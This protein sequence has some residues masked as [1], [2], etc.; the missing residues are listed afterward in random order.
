MK[1]ESIT[2][3]T[4]KKRYLQKSKVGQPSTGPSSLK[5]YCTPALKNT[6]KPHAILYTPQGQ[7]FFCYFLALCS[8]LLSKYSEQ[9]LAHR[10][11]SVNLLTK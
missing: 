11:F 4:K 9:G 6:A 8:L 5:K 3:I 2:C 7:G 10:S 1:L